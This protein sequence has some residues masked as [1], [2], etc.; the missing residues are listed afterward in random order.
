LKL[1]RKLVKESNYTKW[2]E[3][4]NQIDDLNGA[5]IWK[6]QPESQYFDWKHT[7]HMISQL[8]TFYESKRFNEY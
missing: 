4:A 1:E 7:Q 5:T 6:T 2:L 3:L 8:E